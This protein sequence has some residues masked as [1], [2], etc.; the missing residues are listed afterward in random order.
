MAEDFPSRKEKTKLIPTYHISFKASIKH[1]WLQERACMSSLQGP[2]NMLEY[3]FC[4]FSWGGIL[5]HRGYDIVCVFKIQINVTSFLYSRPWEANARQNQKR[6]FRF[7]PVYLV[8][9]GT[10]FPLLLICSF[11]LSNH[12]FPLPTLLFFCFFRGLC[13]SDIHTCSIFILS[14][15]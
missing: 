10:T 8:F 9:G 5:S 12:S 7:L 14:D 3:Q 6:S 4:F 11:F 15:K 13:L 1:L 2:S